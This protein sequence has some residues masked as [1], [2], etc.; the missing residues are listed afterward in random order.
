MFKG[1]IACRNLVEWVK[2]I[3]KPAKRA[4]ILHAL[5]LYSFMTWL[6]IKGFAPK[7]PR[8]YQFLQYCCLNWSHLDVK[9]RSNVQKISTYVEH[10]S[11]ATAL[12]NNLINWPWLWTWR[13][14]SPKRETILSTDRGSRPGGMAPFLF[15][16][17][18]HVRGYIKF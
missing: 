4:P 14:D 10:I 5:D 7:E 11:S 9:K 12:N 15:I 3:F 16:F 1:S 8:K 2:V 6:H 17:H 18:F 13:F